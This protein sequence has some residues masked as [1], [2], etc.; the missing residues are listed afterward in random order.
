MRRDQYGAV[1]RCDTKSVMATRNHG[2]RQRA[3]ATH[4]CR[5]FRNH[6][7]TAPHFHFSP[8]LPSIS[9]CFDVIPAFDVIPMRFR[10]IRGSCVVGT[11]NRAV[12]PQ[13][14]RRP[15]LLSSL[16]SAHRKPSLGLCLMMSR[17][18]YLRSILDTANCRIECFHVAISVSP[19]ASP[20]RRE[21]ELL[22][23]LDGQRRG[24]DDVELSI[25]MAPHESRGQRTLCHSV[26]S[27]Q[28]RL[29]LMNLQAPSHGC[30]REH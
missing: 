8:F 28:E 22:D 27:I 23:A 12:E 26:L 5:C 4:P 30:W 10:F 25:G 29:S 24:H 2:R 20:L 13:M 18:F 1:A 19:R 15:R 11:D 7:P 3:R 17:F 16:L 14:V 9:Q 6:S 21:G